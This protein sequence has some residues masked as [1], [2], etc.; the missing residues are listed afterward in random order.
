MSGARLA[1]Q[2]TKVL[3]LSTEKVQGKLPPLCPANVPPSCSEGTTSTGIITA[4]MSINHGPCSYCASCCTTTEQKATPCPKKLTTD[5]ER[6]TQSPWSSQ[7]VLVLSAE[8]ASKG[9]LRSNPDRPLV[10]GVVPPI[11]FALGHQNKT[12]RWSLRT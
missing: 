9:S 4:P 8:T 5:Q 2:D 12:I 7:L 11:S 3:S 6:L 1:A 10:A